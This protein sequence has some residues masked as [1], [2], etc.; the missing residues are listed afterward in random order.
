MFTKNEKKTKNNPK[1]NQ[2][3]IW[4]GG[5]SVPFSSFLTSDMD[6]PPYTHLNGVRQGSFVI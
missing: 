6:L 4:N 2:N 5:I 3:G 1:Q